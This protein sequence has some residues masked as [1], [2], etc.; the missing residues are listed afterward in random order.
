MKKLITICLFMLIT[1]SVNAQDKKPTKG[2]TVQFI[3][4]SVNNS[5]GEESEFRIDEAK[6]SWKNVWPSVG[7]NWTREFTNVRFDKI[8]KVY[9]S[10]PGGDGISNLI[11][12]F[13]VK[14]IKYH[15]TGTTYDE[16]I[17]VNQDGANTLQFMVPTEKVQSIIKAF[18]RLKEITIEENKDPFQN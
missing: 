3:Q 6:V 8:T 9:E 1:F 18:D 7:I 15:L 5:G 12:E 14:V 4:K 17:E 11:V 10:S 16:A 2:E 13:S